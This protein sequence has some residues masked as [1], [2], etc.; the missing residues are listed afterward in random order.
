MKENLS[1]AYEALLRLNVNPEDLVDYERKL[2]KVSFSEWLKREH[3]VGWYLLNDGTSVADCP[4]DKLQIAGIWISQYCVLSPIHCLEGLSYYEAAAFCSSLR[5]NGFPLRMG[6]QGRIILPRL[7]LINTRLTAAGFPPLQQHAR[8][9]SNNG[10]QTSGGKTFR[11]IRDFDCWET[12]SADID[13][14]ERALCFAVL[15]LSFLQD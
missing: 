10:C 14:D 1:Q 13:G 12:H 11:E 3:A 5:I 6:M 2:M 4:P 8:Y 9:W 7:G 15:D